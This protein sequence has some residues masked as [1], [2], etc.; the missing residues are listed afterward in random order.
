MRGVLAAGVVWL[1]AGYTW[2]TAWY[3]A[4]AWLQGAAAK[5]GWPALVALGAVWALW[6]RRARGDP[7][8]AGWAVFAA[9]GCLL[10]APLIVAREQQLA[11]DRAADTAVARLRERLRLEQAR[12][13]Q[14]RRAEAAARRARGSADRF[15]QY[16]GRL[17]AADLE[18]LRRL[19]AR[20]QEEVRERAGRYAA[21]LASHTT[22][23]PEAWVRF[24]TLA[25]LERERDA[26]RLLY[27][28]TRAFTQFVESFEERYTTAIT[29]LGLAPPADRVA[30][31][32][33][34]RILQDWRRSRLFELRQ[35]DVEILAAAL[36]ALDILRDA[37]GQWEYNPR[38]NEVHFGDPAREAAFHRALQELA[39]LS[40]RLNALRGAQQESE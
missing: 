12:L 39:D 27:E 4:A 32:E 13:E 11:A 5:W 34:E 30:V 15:V 18:A 8:A 29:E 35:L 23:G 14:L 7:V 16:E 33:M 2:V 22:L 9:A 21:A 38:E 25:E 26:H 1:A 28:E 31:A 3:P 20:M 36:R 10:L 17:P 37:W 40:G 19:D 24:R 6:R